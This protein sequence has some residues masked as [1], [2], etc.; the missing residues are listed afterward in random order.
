MSSIAII[1]ARGGS[2][3]IPRKNIRPF[4]GKPI[5]A[6]SIEAALKSGLFSE[7]MVSTDDPEIAEVARQYGAEVPFL[8]SEK[9]SDDTS[10]TVDVLVEVIE[11]YKE[12]QKSFDYACCLY[13]TAPFVT[14]GSLQKAF[15]MLEGSDADTVLPIAAFSFPI[16]KS[17]RRATDGRVSF[18][19]DEYRNYHSQ[20]L[21]KAYHDSGQFYFFRTENFLA[22]RKLFTGNTLGMEVPETQVQDINDEEDWKLAEIK[23]A[24]LNSGGK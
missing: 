6:Y 12:A 20:D 15:E 2:K 8:R 9:N 10:S 19:W 22:Q 5:I 21:P 23:F 7:V 14:A 13:P 16:F 24:Y 11:A 3:R 17:F 1:T 18:T 4:F